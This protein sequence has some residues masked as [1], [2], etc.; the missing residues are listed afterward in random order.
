MKT[1]RHGIKTKFIV[2]ILLAIQ[3]NSS[4]TA[5]GGLPVKIIQLYLC[6]YIYMYKIYICTDIYND[7]DRSS[8]SYID[9]TLKI[10]NLKKGIRDS[11]SPIDI[12]A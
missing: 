10:T 4:L 8:S 3:C 7:I 11:E 2:M 12:I 1:L 9:S 5:A 6:T